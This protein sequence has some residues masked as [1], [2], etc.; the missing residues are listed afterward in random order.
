MCQYSST[1]KNYCDLCKKEVCNKYFLRTHMLK[2]HNIVI[3]ENKSVIANIDTLEKERSGSISFQCDIWHWNMQTRNDLRQHKREAY[4]PPL[5]LFPFA[6]A[7]NSFVTCIRPSYPS[8]CLCD[9]PCSRTHTSTITFHT[10]Y[11]LIQFVVYKPRKAT[12]TSST[13]S[14]CRQLNIYFLDQS[15]NDFEAYAHPLSSSSSSS[16]SSTQTTQ[17]PYAH[18]SF[19]LK[20]IHNNNSG[21][22]FDELVAYLPVKAHIQEPIQLTISIPRLISTL[23]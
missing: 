4:V 1:S 13:T 18:Q 9:S 8:F 11:I 21:L 22:L 14:S 3:D 16:T 6:L 7:S 17:K 2:M 20:T 12:A 23:T 5:S 10:L 15:Q 19:V